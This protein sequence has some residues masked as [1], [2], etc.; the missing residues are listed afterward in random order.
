MFDSSGSNTSIPDLVRQHSS[1]KL[2]HTRPASATTRKLRPPSGKKPRPQSAKEPL[3]TLTQDTGQTFG[4]RYSKTCVKR[5]LSKRP[6]LVFK[7]YLSL[8]AGH[9]YT[10]WRSATWVLFSQNLAS[11]QHAELKRLFQNINF[12]FFLNNSFF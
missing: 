6:K 9:K 1:E 10:F 3:P 12:C 8:N 11:N 4:G 2:L 7:I 5:P